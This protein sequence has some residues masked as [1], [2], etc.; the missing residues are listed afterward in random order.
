[1]KPYTSITNTWILLA[2]SYMRICPIN[3]CWSSYIFYIFLLKVFSVS[4]KCDK[5]S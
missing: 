4:S 2:V 5:I 1:M 3:V